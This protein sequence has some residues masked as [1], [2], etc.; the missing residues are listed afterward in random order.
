M[1]R[2][3]C[4]RSAGYEAT[5]LNFDIDETNGRFEIAF[6]A[7]SL[8]QSCQRTGAEVV[9]KAV[10]I[11]RRAIGNSSA[12][13]HRMKIPSSGQ[14]TACLSS[15]R[16]HINQ[17]QGNNHA[18]PNQDNYLPYQSVAGDFGHYRDGYAGEGR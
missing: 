6:L 7:K 1:S 16:G 9:G 13:N 2:Q 3:A 10:P 15:C 14:S 5:R 17:E 11:F 18:K 4:Y 12:M 8:A